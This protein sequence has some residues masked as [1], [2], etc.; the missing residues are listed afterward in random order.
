MAGRWHLALFHP[1]PDEDRRVESPGQVTLST[2]GDVAA[3]V[4]LLDALDAAI[5]ACRSAGVPL[6]VERVG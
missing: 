4:A 1:L 3:M 6:T 2:L 5:E